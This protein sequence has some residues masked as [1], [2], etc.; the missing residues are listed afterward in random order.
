MMRAVRCRR[1]MLPL[2]CVALTFVSVA[3]AADTKSLVLR[4]SDLPAGFS[5]DKGRYIGN[6]QAVKDL[7]QGVSLADYKRW[8][9]INGYEATFSR[10][11]VV[12][13]LQVVS[14]AS[15]YRTIEGN[16]DSL[17]YSFAKMAK[18]RGFKRVSVGRTIGQE[19]RAYSTSVTSDGV[20]YRV[21]GVLWRYRTVKGSVIGAGVQG[22]VDAEQVFGLARAQQ[23]RIEA[24]LRRG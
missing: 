13:L 8:G 11:T 21:V 10:E 6:A 23:S 18:Q 17:H 20:K 22:T 16:R 2:L 15:S 4:L 12:D 1:L 14:G 5:L 9:R 19:S 3:D 7:E 24:A